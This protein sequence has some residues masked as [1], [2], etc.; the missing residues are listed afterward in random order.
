MFE[1]DLCWFE[2]A[3]LIEFDIHLVFSHWRCHICNI[4]EYDATA[5]EAHYKFY[6]PGE[7]VDSD[8]STDS[9]DGEEE[10]ENECV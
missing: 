9:S 7:P 2:C 5:R 8:C 6:H 4:F 10:E 1:C 3:L